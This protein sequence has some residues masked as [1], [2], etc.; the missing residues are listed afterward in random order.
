M[1]HRKML[2]G[3]SMR[4]SS[5]PLPLLIAL[6]GCTTQTA[7]DKPTVD[8]G[9]L[10]GAECVT[11]PDCAAGLLCGYPIAQGCSAQGVCVTEDR[12]CTNNGPVVC[13]CNGDPVGLACIW[14]PGYAAGPVVS[15]TPGCAPTSDGGSD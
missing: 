15:T 14:G 9:A 4:G 6:A 7:P 8:G 11:T 10:V 5:L 1:I 3:R 2:S 13:G 12:G